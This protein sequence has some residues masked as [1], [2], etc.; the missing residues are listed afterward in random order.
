MTEEKNTEERQRIG[1]R[2]AELR[3]KGGLSQTALAEL[4]GMRQSHIARIETGKISV[5]LDTLTAI[6]DA[7]GARLDFIINQ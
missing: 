1:R 2:I 4:C 7:L 5:G 6:A 3:R